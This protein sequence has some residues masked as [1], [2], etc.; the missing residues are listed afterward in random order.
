M[1]LLFALLLVTIIGV[2]AQAAGDDSRDADTRNNQPA[3]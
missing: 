1:E 3:G 2:L